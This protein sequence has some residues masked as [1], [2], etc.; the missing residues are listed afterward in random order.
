MYLNA[1]MAQKTGYMKFNTVFWAWILLWIVAII[2]NATV[3]GDFVVWLPAICASFFAI[4]LRLHIVR[5]DM[6]TDCG[7]NC[8]EAYKI[9]VHE[10]RIYDEN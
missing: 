6:I 7:K 3:G 8:L 9:D 5:R 10:L 1:Q 4:G 2:L